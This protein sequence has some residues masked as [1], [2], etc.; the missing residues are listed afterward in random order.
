MSEFKSKCSCGAV[1]DVR[2]SA[3]LVEGF[4]GVWQSLHV[5]AGHGETDSRTAYRARK[6]PLIQSEEA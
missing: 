4:K 3:D 5:G 2:G 1:A 6:R